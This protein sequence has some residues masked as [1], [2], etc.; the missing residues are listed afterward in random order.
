MT[1]RDG[2]LAAL[3]AFLRRHRRR[4]IVLAAVLGLAAAV[5]TAH[6]VM[7]GEHM[8]D[9]IVMCLAVA[10]TAV[11]AAAAAIGLAGSR[12]APLP[13]TPSGEPPLRPHRRSAAGVRARAGPPLL[14]VFRL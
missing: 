7:A 8:G 3:N 14:Q 13:H 1:Y 4:V 6:T 12:L 9:G 11:A 10:E 5:V 2:V